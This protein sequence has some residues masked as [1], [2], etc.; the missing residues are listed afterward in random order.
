MKPLPRSNDLYNDDAFVA[1]PRKLQSLVMSR[2]NAVREIRAAPKIS[3]AVAVIARRYNYASGWGKGTL[4]NLYYAYEKSQDWRSLLNK[5]QAGPDFWQTR[6]EVAL[7]LK[8]R[9]LLGSLWSHRERGKF[10][11]AWVDLKAQYRRW[12]DGHDDAAIL[13]YEHCPDP[14]PDTGLPDGWSEGN[15]RRVA[16]KHATSAA[17][18]E[19]AE[20]TRPPIMAE[21]NIRPLVGIIMGS[22]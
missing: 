8:F 11:A 13:G 18:G 19:F 15:L 9:E 2:L 14:R 6:G 17:H 3:Q 7:P 10:R 21:V 12:R 20:K 4:R 1:L 22:Q 5:A 16:K